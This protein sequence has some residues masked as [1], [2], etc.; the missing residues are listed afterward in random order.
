MFAPESVVK[1]K[2]SPAPQID[3]K[4]IALCS[5][6]LKRLFNITYLSQ[7]INQLEHKKYQGLLYLL[8]CKSNL[9]LLKLMLI[10][11]LE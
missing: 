10:L 11:Q 5:L 3:W 2:V 8:E 4:E 7:E 9:R 6:L 1:A